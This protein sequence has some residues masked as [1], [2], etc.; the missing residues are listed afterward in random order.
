MP[1]SSMHSEDAPPKT[2][3]PV[4]FLR[5]TRSGLYYARAGGWT[6]DQAHALDFRDTVAA[7]TFSRRS[8]FTNIEIAV[9]TEQG[10][11]FIPVTDSQPS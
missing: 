5:Q 4:V 8:G 6:G 1:V 2:I 3:T 11:Y 9:K 7:Y 10:E